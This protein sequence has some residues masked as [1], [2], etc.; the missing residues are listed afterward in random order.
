M[1]GN[2]MGESTRARMAGVVRAANAGGGGDRAP[3]A[4]VGGYGGGLGGT[5]G[6]AATNR[7]M[8][9][10]RPPPPGAGPGGGDSGAGPSARSASGPALEQHRLAFIE[11]CCGRCTATD[12]LRSGASRAA[13]ETQCALCRPPSAGRQRPSSAAGVRERVRPASGGARNVWD[14][15]PKELP[16]APPYGTAS[17]PLPPL[18]P[19]S[20]T[21][22]HPAQPHS[23]ASRLSGSA[24]AVRA[25]PLTCVAPRGP[26]A[27]QPR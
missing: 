21:A 8:D 15:L 2:T 27:P 22:P 4:Y 16:K 10:M 7:G 18:P 26:P 25:A 17:E 3:G 13:Y 5:W 20:P 6:K 23:P 14:D 11:T 1:S 24:T 9:P 12:T 19:H